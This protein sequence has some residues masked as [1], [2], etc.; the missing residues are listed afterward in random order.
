[1][2]GAT[3]DISPFSGTLRPFGEAVTLAPFAYV[4]PEFHRL[5]VRRIFRREWISVGRV[6]QLPSFGD[7][8]TLIPFGEPILVVH[9]QHHRMRAFSNVCRH[10]AMPVVSGCGNRSSFPGKSALAT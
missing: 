3:V 2:D 10:R 1:M 6:E 4:D 5:E 9:D 7:Y 8:F